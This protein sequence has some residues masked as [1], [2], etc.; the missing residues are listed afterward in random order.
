MLS[1]IQESLLLLVAV[2]FVGAFARWIPLPSPVTLSLAG[3]ALSFAAPFQ[4]VQLDPETFFVLF[5]PPLLFSDGWLMPIRE[6]WKAKRPILILSVGLVG[7]TIVTVAAVAHA[8]VPGLP[9][10]MAFALGAVVSPTDAVAVSAVTA[11]LKVPYRLTAVL[12]GESLMNDATGLVAF[13]FALAAVAA[14]TVSAGQIAGTF[15]LLAFGGIGLGLVFGYAVGKLRDALLRF[16]RSDDLVETTLSLMTPFGAYFLAE[17]C[18][19]S[20]VLAVVAAGLYSGWRDPIKMELETRQTA[21]SVWSIVLYWL[22]GLAFLLL[23]LSA[24]DVYGLAA[25]MYDSSLLWGSLAAVVA[26]VV[27]GRILWMFPGAYLPRWLFR[28]IR[29]SETAPG[30]KQVFVAGWAGMRGTVTLAAALSI[31]VALTDGSPM[32][33]REI[34]IFLALGVVVVTLFVQSTT[35]GPIIRW[36]GI[37]E[38]AN[39]AKEERLA[40]VSAVE[41]GLAALRRIDPK[42]QSPATQSA[43]AEIIAEYEHRLAELDAEGETRA[44]AKDRLKAGRDF[45]LVA[46]QAERGKLDTLWR[47]GAIVDEIYRPLQSLL[48]HEESMLRAR[49]GYE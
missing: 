30:A 13:R 24:R 31:P 36:F 32:P 20:S 29:E 8:L 43:L 48:D 12:N 45:S 44:E 35:L 34:V 15:S 33:G 1:Y 26:T 18:Q 2:A 14:G 7:F 16:A 11:K 27:I 5:L 49:K 23:G 6:L 38:D 37:Q 21:W 47:R 46:L 40:R 28:S 4:G 25:G 19:V 41:A 3:F 10:A 9:W 39:A 42:S 22:N 17:A